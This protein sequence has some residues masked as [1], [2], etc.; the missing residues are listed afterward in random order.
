LICG[1]GASRVAEQDGR[2]PKDGRVA[3]A[4][5]VI[6]IEFSFSFVPLI[7]SIMASALILIVSWQIGYDFK[8]DP[9]VWLNTIKKIPEFVGVAIPL[10]ILYILLCVPYLYRAFQRISF[11]KDIM[12]ICGLFIPVFFLV[13]FQLIITLV[14]I[15][16]R[17]HVLNL[18]MSSLTIGTFYG[19]ALCILV[20]EG[21]AT[22]MRIEDRLRAELGGAAPAAKVGA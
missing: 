15:N 18:M 7:A 10:G 8:T 14:F 5:G 6:L 19:A 13:T 22:F 20:I 12:I 11:Y 9:W 3:R 2:R 21:Y 4:A 1:R 16:Q 17:E